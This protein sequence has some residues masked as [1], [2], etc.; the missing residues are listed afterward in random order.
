M[1]HFASTY[2]S[3]GS[4]SQGS[5]SATLNATQQKSSSDP[6]FLKIEEELHD[7]RRVKSHGQE[8][9][10]RHALDMVINRVSELSQMLSEAYKAQAELEVQLN[11]TKSNLQ[12]VQ[13]N[14]EMLEEALKRNNAA[15]RDVGWRRGNTPQANIERSQ[16]V[17]YAFGGDGPHSP[18]T[19]QSA[20]APPDNR[21]FNKFRFSSSSAA[22]TRPSSRPGTPS[23]ASAV[24]HLTSPS[25]PSLTSTSHHAKELE[26]LTAELEKE[27]KAK[28]AI[29]DEKAA[30]EAELES[31]SQ[32]LFEEAN[33]M[34]A[35]ERMKRS[36]MEEEL[37]E[38]TMEKQALQSALKLLDG[39]HKEH[40]RN[41]SSGSFAFVDAEGS[42]P[43]SRSSSAM[44]IKSRPDS[45]DLTNSL[46]PLPP[47]PFPDKGSSAA[48]SRYSSPS[49]RPQPLPSAP[50]PPQSAGIGIDVISPTED[51]QPTPR[52]VQPSLQAAVSSAAHDT[53]LTASPQRSSL[54]P[55]ED[56]PWADV[57][58]SSSYGGAASG[59]EGKGALFA[60][61]A[62][63]R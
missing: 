14:N 35:Q 17:D 63:I 31:L 52:Y 60:A 1:Y 41:S 7:A 23:N 2:T 27:R 39:Q 61:A 54:P 40:L 4:S 22:P 49:R 57:A 28:K 34:V 6:F 21:F 9:D 11:V 53:P 38:V 18:S 20:G 24:A 56:S 50:S 16:S 37:K 26:E 42:V 58:G 48:A 45:L 5:K 55:I 25:M 30:L 62:S 32:A 43:P 46:P 44:G 29:A 15:A 19:P 33:K 8:D 51:S 12:L 13:S 36:E 3:P 59:F 47:S 10:L